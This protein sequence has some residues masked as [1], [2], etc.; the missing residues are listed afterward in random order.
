MQWRPLADCMLA[1]S[2]S[3]TAAPSGEGDAKDAALHSRPA[4]PRLPKKRWGLSLAGLVISLHCQL[5]TAEVQFLTR[6]DPVSMVRAA[7]G[8]GTTVILPEPSRV[9]KAW[10]TTHAKKVL[11]NDSRLTRLRSPRGLSVSANGS[12]A[13][14]L[15]VHPKVA[16]INVR[17]PI[18]QRSPAVFGSRPSSWP[19]L[20]SV[21]PSAGFSIAGSESRLG[22]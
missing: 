15:T 21:R 8:G 16:R 9:S 10:P 5:F 14:M 3:L 11:A 19:G 20:W 2:G 13:S 7:L 12:A 6:I 4:P 18:R 22:G 17:P 1:T